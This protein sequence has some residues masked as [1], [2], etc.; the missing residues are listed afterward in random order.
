MAAARHRVLLTL[1]IPL[2]VV[3]VLIAAWAID[4]SQAS[5]RVPRNVTLA[6]EDIGHLRITYHHNWFDTTFERSP[7]VR[8]GE[9]VHVFNNYYF[10]IYISRSTLQ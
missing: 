4:T 10:H 8:F 9:T 3:V 5:G 2:L 7:R 1:A 6:G